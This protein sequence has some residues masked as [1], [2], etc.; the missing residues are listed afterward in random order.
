VIHL[1]SELELKEGWGVSSYYKLYNSSSGNLNSDLITQ[2][3]LKAF[4][5]EN[6]K[7]KMVPT[8]NKAD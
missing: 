2:K 7:L 4:K 5:K 8:C 3:T 6:P 1:D